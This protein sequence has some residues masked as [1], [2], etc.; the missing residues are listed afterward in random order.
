METVY[1]GLAAFVVVVHVAFVA[2]ALAGAVLVLRRPLLAW[3][4]LPAVAWAAF[5]E[6]SGGICPLTPLE[7]MFRSRAGL[8]LYSGDFVARYIFP[9]LYPE[10]LTRGA[11]IAIGLTVLV[12]NVVAYGVLLR[13]RLPR[14]PAAL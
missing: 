13:R 9:V 4:H 8:D 14:T 1:A 5:I 2:F 3:L 11:Q 12:V 6:F 7:N 10:G